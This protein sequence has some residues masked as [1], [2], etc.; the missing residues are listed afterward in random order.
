MGRKKRRHAKRQAHH[1]KAA[2]HKTAHVNKERVLAAQRRKRKVLITWSFIIVAVL[3]VGFLIYGLIP[4][5]SPYVDFA[6]CVTESGAVVYGTDWCDNCQKQKRLFG[7]AF[8]HI[9]YENCDYGKECDEQGVVA[10]PTWIFADGE[11]MRG[12]QSLEVLSEKTGCS[13]PEGV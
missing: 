5:P 13:L 9:M 2:E 4:K 1:A 10:Y 6:L 3:F 8:K 12:W 11:R 7:T